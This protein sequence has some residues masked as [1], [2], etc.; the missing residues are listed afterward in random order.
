VPFLELDRPLQKQQHTRLQST[1]KTCAAATMPWDHC[2]DRSLPEPIT[3]VQTS[4]LLTVGS[5]THNHRRHRHMIM[6]GNKSSRTVAA[7]DNNTGE[8]HWGAASDSSIGE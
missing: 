8:Q 5:A 6:L 4:S 7:L 2:L 1:P 3:H